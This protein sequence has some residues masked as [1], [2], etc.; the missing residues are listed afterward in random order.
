VT[1][2]R[3]AAFWSIFFTSSSGHP[4][5]DSKQV[6]LSKV[7]LQTAMDKLLARNFKVS[8]RVSFAG[9]PNLVANF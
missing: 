6:P 3:W 2:N 9:C 5:R 7:A 8:F 4:G 1:K